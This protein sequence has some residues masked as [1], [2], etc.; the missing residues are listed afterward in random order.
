MQEQL[1]NHSPE[2][3]FGD[4]PPAAGA[5]IEYV[6]SVERPAKP[7]E[8]PAAFVPP[9][10]AGS[11]HS[12]LMPKLVTLL[13]ALIFL[14]TAWYIGP[15]VVEE[16]QFAATRGRQRAEYE[17]AGDVLKNEP[18]AELSKAYQL[19]SQRVAPSVVHINTRTEYARVNAEDDP[20][21][22]FG[23]HYESHGQGS[24]VIVDKEGHILTNYHV[25]RESKEIQVTLSDGRIV[26]AERIGQDEPTDL[27][28]L[29][30][31]TNG[32]IPAEWGDSDELRVGSLVWAVGSP[33]GLRQSVTSGI[34]SAKH[35]ETGHPYQDFMQTDAAVNPG[36]SGGPLVDAQ[37]RVV[38]INTA[39]VGQ[40]YQGI[41]FAIPSNVARQVF[42]Q[43]LAD[44]ENRI[45]R[46]WFGVEMETVTEEV[47]REQ[48]LD[49]PRGALVAAVV[50]GRGGNSP[51]K[52]AGIQEGD[53]VIRWNDA[54]IDTPMALSRQVA[55]SGVGSTA[56]VVVLRNGKEVKVQVEVGR[57]PERLD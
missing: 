31:E 25:V 8:H 10:P 35:R 32:L 40:T 30:V 18:L 39:I 9:Q 55:N 48:G 29:K 52:K 47:A 38:G 11:R 56:D 42:E 23:P 46:G 2:T 4:N 5:E 33:F 34:I 36:N 57:R 27:A 16:Y 1:P 53:I 26:R 22:P 50:E 41:S 37:G 28:L 17:T 49:R 43:L 51:A 44:P 54:E 21:S 7:L 13:F 6:T 20:Y 14:F 19:V 3:P 15:Y 45:A 12:F 24:G